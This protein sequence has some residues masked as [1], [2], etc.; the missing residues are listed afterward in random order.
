MYRLSPYIRHAEDWHSAPGEIWNLPRR[1]IFDYEII[2]FKEGEVNLITDKCTHEIIPGDFVV[3]RPKMPHE[4]INRTGGHVNQPHVH[5]DMVFD[6]LS[7]D[8]YVNFKDLHDISEPD[9]RLFRTDI[10]DEFLPNF[11][12][13]I[14]P[15]H[16]TEL[17]KKLMELIQ[18]VK[19]RKICFNVAAEGILM[20]LISMLIR[21]ISI[22][23]S[24]TTKD[25]EIAFSAQK[26]LNDHLDKDIS[27]DELA[28]HSHVSKYYLCRIFKRVYGV[29]PIRYHR[30]SK[31]NKARELLINTSLPINRIAVM[32]GFQSIYSFSRAFK[33]AENISPSVYR[34]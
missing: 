15:L 18:E 22:S 17:E 27:L 6:D 31:I 21:E 1:V 28:A 9:K 8:V 34:S 14:R 10:L 25:Q 20:Q 26:Y 5:F 30:E 24:I 2:F 33:N 12:T 3:L 29:S 23:S 13:L 7:N 32:T 16:S 11:P 4:F 19:N